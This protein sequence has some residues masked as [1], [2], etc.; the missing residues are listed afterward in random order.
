[1]LGG[2]FGDWRWRLTDRFE[3]LGERLFNYR[4]LYQRIVF[5]QE[6]WG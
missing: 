3:R 6:T 1:M 2:Q 4:S 5:D